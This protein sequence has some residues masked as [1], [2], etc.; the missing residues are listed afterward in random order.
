VNDARQ[1]RSGGA[2]RQ[3]KPPFEAC[4]WLR[5]YSQPART[6]GSVP[7]APSWSRKMTCH[8]VE[9]YFGRVAV[10]GLL[11]P[12]FGLWAARIRLSVP[13]ASPPPAPRPP[14]VVGGTV[15]QCAEGHVA[16]R[17]F[18]SS[19]NTALYGSHI[20]RSTS[21]RHDPDRNP[22]RW[23]V[24]V[25]RARQRLSPAGSRLTPSA[26]EPTENRLIEPTELNIRAPCRR[27]SGP[28][29]GTTST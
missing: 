8:T 13:I 15:K 16:H 12:P 5:T 3:L 29:R 20:E 25:S 17:R 9:V 7:S 6:R 22:G 11:P 18:D 4:V 28:R 23:P 24:R 10:A 19:S 21:I 1:L 27:P 14:R 2:A 26:L